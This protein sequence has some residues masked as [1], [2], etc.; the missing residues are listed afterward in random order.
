LVAD[1]KNHRIVAL[2]LDG[3]IHSL[4]ELR[5]SLNN[6]GT[7]GEWGNGYVYC[8]Y[9]RISPP[10]FG[11]QFEQFTGLDTICTFKNGEV[12]SQILLPYTRV[13]YSGLRHRPL[14]GLSFAWHIAITDRGENY[15]II[16]SPSSNIYMVFAGDDYVFVDGDLVVNV[17]GPEGAGDYLRGIVRTAREQLE[18][19]R[20]VAKAC[21]S[22]FAFLKEGNA[23]RYDSLDHALLA[24]A[25]FANAKD[26]IARWLRGE[27][28]V[29]TLAQL[30]KDGPTALEDL[31]IISL[32]KA[33][34][35]VGERQ[36]WQRCGRKQ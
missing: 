17:W 29:V 2:S 36:V 3:T 27:E 18:W 12:Y 28:I 34:D 4:L 6:I 16:G 25:T 9:N 24:A 22:L 23:E 31:H 10:V 1:T 14:S 20:N 13:D 33:T 30:L 5:A 26:T 15:A 8:S 11:D 35:P 19:Q 32:I 7:P 21:S